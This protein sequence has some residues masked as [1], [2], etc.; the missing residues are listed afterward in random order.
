MVFLHTI[1]F[2]LLCLFSLINFFRYLE[3]DLSIKSEEV[4]EERT[5]STTSRFTGNNIREVKYYLIKRTYESGRIK[6]IKR[7]LTLGE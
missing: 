2:T 3:G 6:F 4:I 7:E 5:L 1:F